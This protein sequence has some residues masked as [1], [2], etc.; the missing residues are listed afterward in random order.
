MIVTAPGE[1][2][3]SLSVKGDVH[4]IV[5]KF[6]IAAPPCAALFP[7]EH[8]DGNVLGTKALN[9]VEILAPDLMPLVRQT[10]DEIHTDVVE[11]TA[12][13]RFEIV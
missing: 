1:P 13:K 9:P 6:R 10:R 12:A 8:V 4:L 3:G 7:V 2:L 11:T 5:L